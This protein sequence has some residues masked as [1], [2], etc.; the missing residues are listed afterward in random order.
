MFGRI[1]RLPKDFNA[2][3]NYD[4]D[5]QLKQ[6]CSSKDPN[7]NAQNT[8]QKKTPDTIK[9]NI[10]KAQKKQKEHY[11][12]RHSTALCFKKGSLVPKKD[13]CAKS[14]KGV[15]LIFS[16]W[17]PMLSLHHLAEDY[18]NLKNCMERRYAKQQPT[19]L[20]NVCA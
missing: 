4:A 2:T 13:F 3:L 11:D 20:L 16:G 18:S 6:F 1:A 19:L 12:R 17:V 14:D 5:E 15:N 7:K 9:A 8:M 10:E